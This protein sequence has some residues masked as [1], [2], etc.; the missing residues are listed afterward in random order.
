[1]DMTV[2]L[3]PRST[4]REQIAAQ[5]RKAIMEG[6]LP[7]GSQLVESRLAQ[8]FGVSRGPLREAIRELIDEGLLISKSYTATFVVELSREDVHEIYSVRTV[9]ESFA[10]ELAW[11]RRDEAFGKELKRRHAALQAAIDHEDDNASIQCELALHSLVFETAGHKLLISMWNSLRGRLQL[12]WAAHHRA[13]GRRGP[14]RDSHD[15]YVRL[16]TGQS[17]DAM[18]E[19]VRNHMLRGARITEEFLDNHLAQDLT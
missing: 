18:K 14:K 19:E 17:L 7:P 15:L 3:L 13:H 1:M 12:Y 10:F 2:E 4:F 16:S 11:D 5:L 8:Q 6:S 9:L